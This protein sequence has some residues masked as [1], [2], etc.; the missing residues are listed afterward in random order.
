MY[1]DVITELT[2]LNLSHT[3]CINVT[4]SIRDQILKIIFYQIYFFFFKRPKYIYIYIMNTWQPAPAESIGV[5][6]VS[7]GAE[8]S[9][10]VGRSC[11]HLDSPGRIVYYLYS[12]QKLATAAC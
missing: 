11:P 12:K 8:N 9:L 1:I 4:P 3:I 7:C 6:H 2:T 10:P 5:E